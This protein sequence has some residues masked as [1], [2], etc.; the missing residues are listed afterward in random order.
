M[1]LMSHSRVR[2]FVILLL[3]SLVLFALVF[4]YSAA[5]RMSIGSWDREA[6]QSHPGLGALHLSPGVCIAT[7][8]GE[9]EELRV[10]F[11]DAQQR[12]I[13]SVSASVP[14]QGLVSREVVPVHARGIRVVGEQSGEMTFMRPGDW[15]GPL[16]LLYLIEP[17]SSG[18]RDLSAHPLAAD[19]PVNG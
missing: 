10:E 5:I 9:W 13:S 12:V 19:L 17:D 18:T 1:P 16:D 4:R 6:L 14:P 15:D 3:A 7:S 2:L 8:L 11:L